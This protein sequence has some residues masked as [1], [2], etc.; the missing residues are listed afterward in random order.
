MSLAG[1]HPLLSLRLHA[2]ELTGVLLDR[3]LGRTGR[4]ALT[5]SLDGR[6][7]L[8][9]WHGRLT[10]S[11][12]ALARLDAN[13][14][15]E[16]GSATVLGLSGKAAVAPLLPADLASPVGGS[17][18]FSL[19][20]S[21]D[22]RI[23]VNRLSIDLAAGTLTGEAVS[24]GPDRA[25]A[26]H[27]R[28]DL[29]RLA[30]LSGIAG[31]PLEGAASLNIGV[32]GSQDHPVVTADLTAARIA[33]A[34]SAAKRVAV[35]VAASPTGSLA[36]AA[37]R[38]AVAANGRI[39]GLAVAQAGAMAQRLGRHIDW[40]LA[41]T[42]DRSARAIELTRIAVDGGGLALA[43]SGQLAIA[44]RATYGEADFTGSAVGMRTGIAAVDALIGGKAVFAGA[45][46]RAP[47]GAVA[48]D[49]VTLTGAAAKLSGHAQFDPAA[50][51][52]AAALTLD[53]P[54]L[55]PLGAALGTKLAGTASAGM[56]A[57]GAARSAAAAN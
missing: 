21:F 10:A 4:P 40:S 16:V 26:A 12:G 13:V 14:A 32:T 33:A 50:H 46:R 35:H 9:D 25:I 7:P 44:G 48:L 27:L 45:V 3:W 29:P 6:G 56:T 31:A 57:R 22:R 49:H 47:A 36:D 2:D 41:A 51:L 52:L 42:A 15:L 5:L 55:K 8:A 53:V 23:V 28:A 11:A 18:G 37:T 54:Q 24:G 19:R 17:V 43:G 38:I 30:L 20:A 34:G 1:A 39:E